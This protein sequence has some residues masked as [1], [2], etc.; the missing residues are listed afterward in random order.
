MKAP[1]PVLV[2]NRLNRALRYAGIR[3]ARADSPADRRRMR[4]IGRHRISC[5][6]DVGANEGQYGRQLRRQGY[7]GA[8]HSYEPL[9][10]P[11]RS[12][13]NTAKRDGSWR[14]ENKAVSD[15]SGP[16][17]MHV[18]GNSV[19][20]S[21]LP[22]TERHRHAAPASEIISTVTVG[23]ISLAEILR[24][25]PTAPTMVKIDTQGHEH[26][27][28]LS[29]CEL[30]Q[31][32]TLLELELSFVEL[33]RG[34]MLFREMDAFLIEKGLRLVSL[35][36]GFFD[37]QSG[38]LLQADAIYVNDRAAAQRSNPE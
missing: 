27:V 29:A 28:L 16:L 4:L 9:P 2:V 34:Q 15:S 37:E 5:V 23:S 35:E 3:L 6:V 11:F 1:I 25:L 10:E 38:E 32:I 36:D 26:S 18:A 7:R 12:L 19:S 31:S 30:L 20:S 17:V 8:I 22:M 14:A 24:S 13:A 21:L 33:Y